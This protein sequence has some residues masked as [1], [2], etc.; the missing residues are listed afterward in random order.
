MGD[1]NNDRHQ[2]KQYFFYSMKKMMRSKKT[3]AAYELHSKLNE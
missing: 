3:Q 1:P 2:P